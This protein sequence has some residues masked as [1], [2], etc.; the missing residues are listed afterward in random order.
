VIGKPEAAPEPGPVRLPRRLVTAKPTCEGKALAT[1]Q[2]DD[3]SPKD[4]DGS[5]QAKPNNK[6]TFFEPFG[7]PEI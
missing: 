1:P 6:S 2:G 3:G 5:F 4:E 7:K